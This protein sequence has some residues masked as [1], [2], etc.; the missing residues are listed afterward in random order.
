MINART[1]FVP[2]SLALIVHE[3][4]QKILVNVLG[5]I[6]WNCLEIIEVLLDEVVNVSDEVFHH[7]RLK[8]RNIFDGLDGGEIVQVEFEVRLR[9]SDRNSSSSAAATGIGEFIDSGHCSCLWSAF[10]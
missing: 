8:S 4:G 9:R 5:K 10:D 6:T 1:I 7:V 3:G 2:V